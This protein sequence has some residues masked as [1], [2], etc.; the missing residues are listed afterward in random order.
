[1]VK[2][3]KTIFDDSSINAVQK[4]FLKSHQVTASTL[5]FKWISTYY[6]KYK[7]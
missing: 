5:I 2:T 4:Q 1:M 6:H 3:A 7:Y